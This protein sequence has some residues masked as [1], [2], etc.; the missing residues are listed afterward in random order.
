MLHLHMMV[1]G[2]G[3]FRESY[4]HHTSNVINRFVFMKNKTKQNNKAKQNKQQNQ[5]NITYAISKG[6]IDSKSYDGFT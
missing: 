6:M 2:A 4:L 5:K 1:R 3:L